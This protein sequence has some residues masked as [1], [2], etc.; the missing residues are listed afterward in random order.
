MK[1]VSGVRIAPVTVAGEES[2]YGAFGK[3]KPGLE[4]TLM[5]HELMQEE[6]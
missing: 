4:Q 3:Q 1:R 2:F 5:R 6:R